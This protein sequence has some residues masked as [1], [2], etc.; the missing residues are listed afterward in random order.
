M[1]LFYPQIPQSQKFAGFV[2]QRCPQIPRYILSHK[3][4]LK[5]RGRKNVRHFLHK[6]VRKS[7]GCRYRRICGTRQ[8]VQILRSKDNAGFVA[9]SYRQQI[10]LSQKAGFVAESCP[11]NSRSQKTR[12]VVC[13]SRTVAKAGFVA[14][15]LS[16]S[17]VLLTR[18]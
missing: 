7:R 10:P 17:T 11:Q 14:Q 3:V 5:S 4:I 2:A 1:A 12:K 6:V 16:S 9:Q 18:C 15:R 8:S 13:K